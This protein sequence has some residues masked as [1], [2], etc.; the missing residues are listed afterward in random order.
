[1][2]YIRW[3]FLTLSA[4]LFVQ[5]GALTT[6][7][8]EWYVSPTGRDTNSGTEQS[9]FLTLER[10][11]TA[12][13]TALVQPANAGSPMTVWLMAGTYRLST[14]FGLG[15]SDSGASATAPVLYAAAPGAR[16]VLSG[17]TRIDRQRFTRV[18]DQ[19]VLQRIVS[20]DA[21]SQILQVDLRAAGITDFGVL[22]RRG[23]ANF[24]AQ[25]EQPPPVQLFIDGKRM[26]LARWPNP[27]EHF[28][29]LLDPVHRER[30]GVVARSGIVSKGPTQTDGDYKTRGGTFSVSFDR[31]QHWTNAKEIWLVGVFSESWE[32]SYNR[33]ASIDVAQRRL[34]LAYGEASGIVDGWSG[35]F[36]YAENLLEEID[37]AGE[38]FLDRERGVLYVYP[39]T[40]WSESSSEI[41]LATLGGT[42]ISVFEASNVSFRDLVLENARTNAAIVTT[43]SRNVRVERCEIRDVAGDGISFFAGTSNAIVSCHLHRIGGAP[44]RIDGGNLTTLEPSNSLAEGNYIHHWGWYNKV[45]TGGIN[46][47]GVAQRAVNNFL[48]DAPHFA[49]QIQDGNDHVVEG[50]RIQ[51][52]AT[53]FV[54]A[55]AVY[56]GVGDRPL[57]RG[58]VIRGN[59]F[60]DIGRVYPAQHA[61][62]ADNLSMN[63]TI[64]Q[65]VFARIGMTGLRAPNSAAI[66][67]NSGAY[68]AVRNNTFIDCIVP[69]RLSRYAGDFVYP[70]MVRNWQQIWATTSIASLP[71]SQRYPELL[72]FWDEPRQFP[73]TNRYENNIV[74]NPTVD[75]LA[76][77]VGTSRRDGAFAEYAGVQYGSNFTTS[78]DPGFSDA[79]KG[80]FS[81]GSG[82]VTNQ[83]PG[84]SPAVFAQIGV[85]GGTGP[86]AAQSP[87][88]EADIPSRLINLSVRSTIDSDAPTLIAGFVM[89]GTSPKQV[90]LRGVGPTLAQ[91][92]VK[93]ALADPR[94]TL[95]EGSGSVFAANDDWS[96][97][98]ALSDAFARVGAFGLNASSK[99]AALSSSLMPGSYTAQVSSNGG[100]GVVLVEGYEADSGTSTTRL[101]NLSTRAGAGSGERILA[102]GIVIGG[103]APKTL[104]LRGI[105]PSLA[106]FGV[107]GA[108]DDPQLS[109][110]DRTSKVIKQN[111]N[112]GGTK[113]FTDVFRASGA[114]AL[115]ASSKDAALHITLAPGLY[116]LQLSAT[117][118]TS[119][120]ALVEVYDL[121]P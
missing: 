20:V 108:M 46:L 5:F 49:I 33:V 13:R 9:P 37:E 52:V 78:D 85:K 110:F 21:R 7:A 42:M 57:Q 97:T 55:A 77:E 54:D 19:T 14:S 26:R 94:I 116:T 72:R 45:Y 80:D 8:A 36:F 29:A 100:N 114:F 81:L 24:S 113:T 27:T 17:A 31:L 43:R 112:W 6:Q 56:G 53:E 66:N 101:V 11:R 121:D 88:I 1:M 15:A 4:A 104:L 106:V 59:Y 61:V 95:F 22:S 44:I 83:L 93:D 120:A 117:N 34:T 10:A 84:F 71:H 65:N 74:W 115:A 111:D 48:H 51:R 99:D 40:G 70:N 30:R 76:A 41:E 23:F 62:Y 69:Y 60:S 90:L 96:G 12:V 47:R 28:A 67:N 75:L 119:G 98:P 82:T 2:L 39:P 50:N 35:N 25:L 63:W 118:N 86:F 79:L 18:S 107:S 3:Y 58:H 68:V 109:L 92:G 64:E 73:D 89:R 103:V 32:W 91:F 102:V 16:V 38:Y 105:G 87:M